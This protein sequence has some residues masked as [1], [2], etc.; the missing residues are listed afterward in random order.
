MPFSNI[1][2]QFLKCK[3]GSENCIFYR[4][5]KLKREPIKETIRAIE[6][7]VLI[8]QKGINIAWL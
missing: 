7:Q 5:S 2:Q 8:L 3:A 6:K 4:R 1:P